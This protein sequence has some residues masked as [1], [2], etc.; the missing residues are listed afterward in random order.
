MRKTQRY[1]YQ[2]RRVCPPEIHFQVQDAFLKSVRF[3]GGGCPGN[4]QLVSRLLEGMPIDEVLPILNGIACSKGSSCPDQLAEAI[5]A[6]QKGELR[7]V[8][9]FRVEDIPSSKKVVGLIGALDGDHRVLQHLSASMEARGVQAILCAGNLTSPKKEGRTLIK[10]ISDGGLRAVTGDRDWAYACE[11]ETM[12]LPFMD[13]KTK[14][15]LVRLPQV[16]SFRMDDRKGVM[17][18]G[19]Y[20]QTM[21][22]YS[23]FEP[24]ALEINMVCG[25]TDFMRDESVF[26]ALEAMDPQ[27]RADIIIFSQ[28]GQWGHWHLAGKDFISLGPAVGKDGVSWA[29]LE[30]NSGGLKFSKIVTRDAVGV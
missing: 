11:T 5:R 25:L 8:S 1:I 16:I 2:T 6:M 23:D 14:D 27:F 28:T 21:P 17:F 10:A 4:A 18:F 30:I 24:Y 12:Q 19:D 26:P 7:P 3:V 20:I 29:C 9:S 13:S 22:G 15:F